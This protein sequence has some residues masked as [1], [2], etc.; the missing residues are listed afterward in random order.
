MEIKKNK[1]LLELNREEMLVIVDMTKKSLWEI[2]NGYFEF[3]VANGYSEYEEF[4]DYVIGSESV[5]FDLLYHLSNILD[6]PIHYNEVISRIKYIWNATK[7]ATKMYEEQNE[8]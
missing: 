1:I 4:L 7:G 6:K 2:I 5:K 3:P 8:S